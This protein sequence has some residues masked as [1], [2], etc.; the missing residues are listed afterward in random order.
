MKVL[1]TGATGF[2]G[3]SVCRQLLADG[4]EVVALSR[5]LHGE[6]PAGVT[7]AIGDVTDGT[8][9][10]EAFSGVDAVIHLVGIIRERRGVTFRQVHVEGTRNVLRAAEAAGVSRFVQMSALGAGSGS[11]SAY[12]ESKA[13]AEQLVRESGLGWTILRPSLMFGKGDD[14]FGGTLR[15]LVTLPPVV[16]VVGSGAYLFRP[17]AVEDVALAAARAPR[18][19]E[20]IGREF[21]LTG[22]DEF[23]L[24]ELLLLVRETLGLRKPLLN[25]PLP[26]MRLGVA[27]FRVLP[28]PPVTKDEFLML[29]AGNTA[30]PA[31]AREAFGLE[32]TRLRD[33]LPEILEAAG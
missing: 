27:L 25:I 33:R 2:V 19:P 24:R 16:P 18:L 32:L 6:A 22:P 3:R 30:D 9:L 1:V 29:L 10:A 17:V 4:R 8:G 7:H 21:A 5:G 13:E 11:G 15:Q 23:S 12:H 26:L 28:N 31:P 14:F 20:T